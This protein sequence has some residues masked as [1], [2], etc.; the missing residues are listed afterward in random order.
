[1]GSKLA[2]TARRVHP[3]GASRVIAG[4]SMGGYVALA[5]AKRYPD[6]LAALILADT[7]AST[8]STAVK[9]ARV[10]DARYVEQAAALEPVEQANAIFERICAP[11]A[12]AWLF[13]RSGRGRED[14][15]RLARRA[16]RLV[17]ISGANRLSNLEQ[18]E[19]F[20]AAV[21]RFA[22]RR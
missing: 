15:A 8:D 3:G 12:T 17:M 11:V 14:A 9:D 18:P 6:R 19:A 5:F 13:H 7:H 2:D 20:N 1:M 21:K 10:A 4:I 16:G 22:G